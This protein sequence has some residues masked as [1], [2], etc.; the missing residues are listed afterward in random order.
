MA[1]LHR[2]RLLVTEALTG[3]DQGLRQAEPGKTLIVGRTCWGAAIICGD[4]SRIEK[5]PIPG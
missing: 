4:G 2:R 3:N 1:A 5:D